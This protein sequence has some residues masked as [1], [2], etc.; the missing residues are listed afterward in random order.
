MLLVR[1]GTPTDPQNVFSAIQEFRP[2]LATRTDALT[3]E[4]TYVFPLG[5]DIDSSALAFGLPLLS[6]LETHLITRDSIDGGSEGPPDLSFTAF[7]RQSPPADD[8]Y[9]PPIRLNNTP[10]GPF[11]S[12]DANATVM[13]NAVISSCKH[14]NGDYRIYFWDLLDTPTQVG[15]DPL[16]ELDPEVFVLAPSDFSFSS[17]GTNDGLPANIN[18]IEYLN[19]L[20]FIR[21]GTNQPDHIFLS[22]QLDFSNASDGQNFAVHWSRTGNGTFSLSA[23]PYD[24]LSLPT[25]PAPSPVPSFGDGTY[26]RGVMTPPVPASPPVLLGGFSF[27][28]D[29]YRRFVA[30]HDRTGP[31]HIVVKDFWEGPGQT[32]LLMPDDI[33]GGL[34]HPN[35]DFFGLGEANFPVGFRLFIARATLADGIAQRLPVPDGYTFRQVT[36]IR[37]AAAPQLGALRSLS[38]IVV[39][40]QGQRRIIMW[41][42]RARG[43]PPNDFELVDWYVHG[44]TDDVFD[45]NQSGELSEDARSDHESSPLFDPITPRCGQTMDRYVVDPNAQV[46]T[47]ATLIV[48]PT[49]DVQGVPAVLTVAQL[50]ATGFPDGNLVIRT[51]ANSP[52]DLLPEANL[53]AVT[54][55]NPALSQEGNAWTA[56]TKP[57]EMPAHILQMASYHGEESLL[58]AGQPCNKLYWNTAIAFDPTVP[59]CVLT[60]EATAANTT[61]LVGGQIPPN[62]TWPL[63]FGRV[64]LTGPADENG[65][66]SLE[67]RQHPLN[68]DELNTMYKPADFE[69]NLCYSFGAS[70]ANPTMSEL[71]CSYDALAYIQFEFM[72]QG[73]GP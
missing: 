41:R 64:P 12:C 39:D 11:E 69:Y 71:G 63:I 40:G 33:V 31:G 9:G 61:S 8:P 16:Y 55:L 43:A 65:L 49:L 52:V 23:P 2:A 5:S 13:D 21:G 60:F 58:C 34:F 29:G 47:D 10:G 67:C 6:D 32:N 56:A 4:L 3:F 45:T 68:S 50:T 15:V 36:G 53:E 35:G 25:D 51:P 17:A 19:N 54:L 57:A 28:N 44:T 62:T 73:N 70:G 14:V 1:T 30:L 24:Q 59:D 38:G 72:L 20:S 18:N 26:I 66:A 7:A 46:F 22:A 48:D 37:G 27:S 42:V